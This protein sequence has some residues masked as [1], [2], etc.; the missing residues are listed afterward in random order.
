MNM[1]YK[2]YFFFQKET[3]KSKRKLL[4]H[5]GIRRNTYA[6]NVVKRLHDYFYKNAIDLKREYRKYYRKEFG[7]YKEYLMCRLNMPEHVAQ[8]LC[9]EHSC[10]VNLKWKGEHPGDYF[11]YDD[12]LKMKFWE[13]VGGLEIED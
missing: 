5:F 1:K 6:G 9:N 3:V 10:Y 13:F 8:Q 4:K 11:E 2:D 7:D 12:A